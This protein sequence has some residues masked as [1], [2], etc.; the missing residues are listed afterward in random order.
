MSIQKLL[1]SLRLLQK[2]RKKLLQRLTRDHELAT[3]TVSVVNR[4]CGSPNCHCAQGQGH[5]QMLF[6]FNDKKGKRRCKLVRKADEGRMQKAGE[7]YRQFRLDL[8]KLR[9]IDKKEKQI[10]M[11]I[12]EKRAI[13]YT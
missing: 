6:L 8:R 9:A 13:T 10:I 3:G 2:E 11:A 7:C 5:P 12:K 4:K 1:E